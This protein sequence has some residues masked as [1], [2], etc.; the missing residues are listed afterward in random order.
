MTSDELLDALE[1]PRG[2]R[3]LRNAVTEVLRA[4]FAGQAP[5]LDEEAGRA[6]RPSQSWLFTTIERIRA[7]VE[8]G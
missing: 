2:Q 8:Q 4:G 5:G 1:S 3:A 6:V 7:K